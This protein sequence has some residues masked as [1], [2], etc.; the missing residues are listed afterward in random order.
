MNLIEFFMVIILV[1]L[2]KSILKELG[3]AEVAKRKIIRKFD[4]DEEYDEKDDEK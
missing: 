4:E 3:F 1:L 2:A